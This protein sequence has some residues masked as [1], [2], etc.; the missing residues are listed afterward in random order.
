MTNEIRVLI[1]SGNERESAGL[2]GV[3]KRADGIKV[4][5][6]V[7]GAAALLDSITDNRPSALLLDMDTFAGDSV[8]A[9]RQVM[10]KSPLPIIL[11]TCRERDNDVVFESIS[12]GALTVVKK[13]VITNTLDDDKQAAKVIRDI[14]TY[15]G[16]SVIRHVRGEASDFDER[17]R[18]EK[19]KFAPAGHIVAIASSTGGPQALKTVLCELPASFSAGIVVAQHISQGFTPGLIDWLGHLCSIKFKE[20]REGEKIMPGTAYFAPDGYHIKVRRFELIGLDDSPP[21]GGHRP[22]CNL[23]LK[24]AAE[25]Y[26][27]KAVGVI[28]SGMG[29]DGAAGLRA[30]HDAGGKTFAQDEAS[31]AVFGMPN[32]AMGL[33]A[34]TK[35]TPLARIADEII[36]A[37]R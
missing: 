31:S 19:K 33:G 37:V 26:G 13:P 1:A 16:I 9:V 34:V 27:D 12:A 18:A 35:T 14:R 17:T 24:S 10:R 28:L 7:A 25:V 11:M 21:I 30:I 32:V 23:L 15:S 3:L 5:G 2:T 20:G 8:M 22:S 36:K 4:V 6:T 29:E